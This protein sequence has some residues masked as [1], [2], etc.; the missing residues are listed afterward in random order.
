MYC[1]KKRDIQWNAFWARGRSPKNFVRAQAIFHRISWLESQKRNS[2]LQ[3]QHCPSWRSIF[4]E[5]IIHT[6]PTAG[7]YRKIL[8]IRLN[9]YCDERRNI[10]WNIAWALGKSQ[11]QSPRD[12]P[13]AQAIFHCNSRL[14]SQ[15]SH[16]QLQ[17]HHWP[18]LEINIGK[19]IIRFAPTA[20]QYGKILPS[21]LFYSSALASWPW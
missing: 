17:L 2:Q 16:S 13:R 14:K 3:H 7:Q 1:D 19:L 15:Y 5:L 8:P 10:L 6:V 21:R 12:F 20:G 9:L 4:E 11:K 18:S